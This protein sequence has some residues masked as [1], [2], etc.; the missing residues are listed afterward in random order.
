[1]GSYNMDKKLDT[2]FASGLFQ[3]FTLILLFAA[4]LTRQIG[5]VWLSVL[6]LLLFNGSRLWS[7]YSLKRLH[8]YLMVKKN[9]A[10]PPGDIPLEAE[11]LNNKFLP[12]WLKIEVPLSSALISPVERDYLEESCAL[13]WYQKGFW[14]WELP[15]RQRGAYWAGPLSIRAGDLM[16]FY[17]HQIDFKQYM[18]I[19]IYPRIIP[20]APFA[21]KV[22]EFFGEM[23]VRSPVTD[24]VYPVATRDYY[25]GRPAR[26]IH[27]KAS[28]RHGRLQEKIFEPTVQVR[29]LFIID[30]SQFVL[31]AEE[32]DGE[33]VE[34]FERTL[35]ATASLAVKYRDMGTAVG[36]ITNGAFRGEAPSVLTPESSTEQLSSFLEALARLQMKKGRGFED[37]L[38]GGNNLPSGAVGL[39]FSYEL[40]EGT[41][42][43]AEM[44]PLFN[45]PLQFITA[46]LPAGSKVSSSNIYH[47][48]DICLGEGEVR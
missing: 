27:W 34:I 2:V 18:E 20:V 19:I 35:E 31:K 43:T 32:G 8:G 40:D 23:G 24:P 36:L 6:I 26:F 1:M 38:L 42:D 47:L 12:V 14:R 48:K 41:L 4:L 22:K 16:G 46:H 11:V 15:A 13:L 44:F 39:H 3:V 10:F 5:L 30:V 45:V 17:E 21:L 9:R 28:A 37:L 29:V 25:P 7:L 33:A